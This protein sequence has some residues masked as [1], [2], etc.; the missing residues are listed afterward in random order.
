MSGKRH[1]RK[2]SAGSNVW[3]MAEAKAGLI[4][5]INRAEELEPQK[6]TRYGEDAAVIVAAAEWKRKLARNNNLAEF[7][8]KSPLR[9]SKL[10]IRRWHQG[11]RAL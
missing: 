7:L 6:I 10:K 11:L 1:I 4:E 2:R 5:L 8:A 9:G 3:T